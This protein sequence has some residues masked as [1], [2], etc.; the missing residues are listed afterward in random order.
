MASTTVKAATMFG[1]ADG[2]TIIVMSVPI[3]EAGDHSPGRA[4]TPVGRADPGAPWSA[5]VHILSL[6]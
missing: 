2:P 3:G 5:K 1:R 4:V 6:V